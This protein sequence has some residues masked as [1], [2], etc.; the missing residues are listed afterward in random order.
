[1]KYFIY[2]RK[3][4]EEEERQALSIE[5]QLKELRE[6]ANKNK[7]C[8]V[9]EFV[10]A[11]SARKPNNRPTFNQLLLD[12]Q[13]NKADGILS[14]APD[15]LSRNAP[16][17]ALIVDLLDKGII[18]D[19]KFP[20]FYF[21][22]GPQGVFNLSLAF[23]FGKLYVDNLSQ[24]VKRGIREKVRRGEFPG[25]APIGY[26]N[27]FKKKN[28]EADPEHF[29]FV[30]V[31][32]EKYADGELKTY[33]IKQKFFEAGIK[34]RS[35]GPVHLNTI[36]RMLVNPFYTGIFKLKDELYPG[37]HPKMIS[38]ETFEK[39][40]KRLADEAR[41][42]DWSLEK[43]DDKGFLFSDLGKCGE[44]GYTV[45][46]DYHR[47]KSGREFRYYRCT[48]KSK[49]C[50]CKQPALNEKDMASQIEALVSEIA[51]DDYW[52]QWCLDEIKSWAEAEKDTIDDQFSQLKNEL[53]SY[54][55][56]L[57][58][59][60]DIHIDGALNS[61]EYK[62]KKNKLVC[63][64]KAIEDKI[65]QI[66]D[67]GNNWFELLAD[68][69]KVSNQAHHSIWNQDFKSM[70]KT[71]KKVGSN[72]ILMD[73]KYSL[74]FNKPFCFFREAV[75]QSCINHSPKT[76]HHKNN[77]KTQTKSNVDAVRLNFCEA[78]G[79]TLL[80]P[81]REAPRGASKPQAC[82]LGLAS[83]SCECERKWRT[84]RDS[85]SRTRLNTQSTS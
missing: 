48:K 9:D 76:T 41:K 52:Y 61:E 53:D 12:L 7:L 47:K 59:L 28:I 25:P 38:L 78:H 42:V 66:K 20:S 5:S 36:R 67:K 85:N 63:E 6:Y 72:P 49:K 30:K 11:K 27:N 65:H 70:G 29:D 10:E 8:V 35:G 39:I 51:I 74:T 77:L 80:S 83:G 44:C 54:R 55:Q 84:E 22:P 56:R 57:E 60:L 18:K 73:K 45:I 82:E 50:N 4:S 40:Q 16:E 13:T 21:E 2:C 34:T 37:S 32:L 64:S 62:S 58:R 3:S 23:N 81:K 15:R 43:R 46:Q 19:L 26:I 14:W 69:L 33:E 68:S 79:D 75:S 24:N 31:I 17:G 71:L 1:M